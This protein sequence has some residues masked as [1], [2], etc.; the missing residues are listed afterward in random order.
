MS[1]QRLADEGPAYG[2]DLEHPDLR[3]SVEQTV[4]T[5]RTDQL[6]TAWLLIR[7]RETAPRAG[8]PHTPTELG[9]DGG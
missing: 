6:A 7:W 8:S 4:S 2:L 5:R 1:S 3:G 9:A